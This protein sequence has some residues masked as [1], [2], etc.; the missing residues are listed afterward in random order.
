MIMRKLVYTAI[1]LA[2]CVTV[3]AQKQKSAKSFGPSYGIKVGTNWSYLTGNSQGFNMDTKTGFMVSGFYS[4]PSS[5]MGYRTEIVFSRQGYSFEEGGKNTDILNDYIYLPQLTTF[6]IGNVFQLQLGAQV[7]FLLNAK[8]Q[9]E[10][11]DS[12]IT[13]LMNRFDYGFAGGFEIYPFKGLILGGRYN[14]GLGKM[15]KENQSQMPTQPQPGPMP[16]PLPFNPETTNFKNG[17][18][19]IFIGYKF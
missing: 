18:L 7:G 8:K 3:S 4:M 14:L 17:V 13:G 16:I 1:A 12:S 5:G 15:Y 2:F 19:Q 6:T 11:K 9:T 10:T